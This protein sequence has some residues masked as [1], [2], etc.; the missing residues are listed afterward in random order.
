MGTRVHSHCKPRVWPFSAAFSESIRIVYKKKIP[1]A[2]FNQISPMVRSKV[3]FM[4]SEAQEIL[5]K[6][7]ELSKISENFSEA[8]KD[9]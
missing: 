4:L 7:R 6:F 2:W 9:S 1:N 8:Q 3:R 5:K